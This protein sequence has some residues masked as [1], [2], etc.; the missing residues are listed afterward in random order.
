MIT[1]SKLPVALT[2]YSDREQ[3]V[4]LEHL[5]MLSP[6]FFIFVKTCP[7]P[8]LLKNITFSRVEKTAF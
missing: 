5:C 8:R 4:E 1:S 2:Y 6:R 3:F 7:P